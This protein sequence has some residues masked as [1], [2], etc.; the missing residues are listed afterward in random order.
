MGEFRA[1]VQLDELLSDFDISEKNLHKI[2]NT[3]LEEME[4][5]LKGSLF[6]TIFILSLLSFSEKY[7]NKRPG[8]HRNIFRPPTLLKMLFRRMKALFV[9]KKLHLIF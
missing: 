3:M 4:K 5:G 2:K 9:G 7:G 1:Y 6:L 8:Y